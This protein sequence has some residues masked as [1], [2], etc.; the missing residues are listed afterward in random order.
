MTRNILDHP[1]FLAQTLR[2][3]GSVDHG[4]RGPICVGIPNVALCQHRGILPLVCDLE[5]PWHDAAIERHGALFKMAFEKACCCETPTTEAELDDFID[6]TFA[7]LNRRVGR[8]GFAPTPLAVRRS[9]GSTSRV[10]GLNVRNA[11]KRGHA[12]GCRKR[13]HR[14]CRSPSHLN[15]HTQQT[16]DNAQTNSPRRAIVHPSKTLWIP[17]MRWSHFL[18][19]QGPKRTWKK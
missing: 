3:N 10:T 19:A 1:T 4:P 18:R 17:R 11:Q 5:T 9:H 13:V 7:E 15:R 14:G 12:L 2:C 8:A 6:F 16:K